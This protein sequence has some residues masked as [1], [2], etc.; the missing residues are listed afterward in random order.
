MSVTPG[1]VSS[2]HM[3]RVLEVSRLLT[4]TADLDTLLQ[5]IAEAACGLLD[6]ERASI[7][8]YDPKT[9]ELWTKVALQSREIRVSATSGIVGHAF[10]TNSLVHVADPY[11]DSR[12]NPEPDKRSGFVTRNLLTIPMLDLDGAPVGVIQAVNKK[13]GGSFQAID[14]TMLELLADQAGVAI[15]RYGLQQAAMQA[16]ALRR[17]MELAKGLQQALIP[18]VV[19]PI[20]GID[21]YGWAKTAS[22]T[23]GDSYDLWRTADG[24]LGLFL[25]DATGHG[26]APAMVVAQART[27]VRAM[28]EVTDDPA[29]LLSA[30]NKRLAEDLKSDTFVTAFVGFLATDGRFDWCSAG[31]GPILVRTGYDTP[32]QSLDSSALP[33]GILPALEIDR[34]KPM[35]LGEGGVICVTSDG[36]IE[37]FS[38]DGD[39][40]GLERL[41]PILAQDPHRFSLADLAIGVRTAVQTWQQ[42]DDPRDDQTLIIAARTAS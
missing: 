24:R 10:K 28:C 9:D 15:Q 18:G 21:A 23:G 6:C 37:A 26:I 30:A 20:P 32:M 25:G 27:L 34:A 38:P 42:G 4:V 22:M 41:L 36:I 19:P 39:Q 13:A 2:D 11:K 17:E 5:H 7:F 40:F 1:L 29:E 12:F 31:H 35:T 16:T 3:R 33:L 14:E 8:L